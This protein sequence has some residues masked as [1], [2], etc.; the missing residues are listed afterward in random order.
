[1]G[2]D[3]LRSFIVLLT[4]CLSLENQLTLTSLSENGADSAYLVRQLWMWYEVTRKIVNTQCENYYH[5]KHEFPLHIEYVHGH[6][7]VSLLI[8]RHPVWFC[9]EI[10]N[11]SSIPGIIQNSL[12]TCYL[13]VSPSNA[14]SRTRKKPKSLWAAEM[15]NTHRTLAF[16]SRESPWLTFDG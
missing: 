14:L 11:G 10:V 13:A 6:K 12:V 5:L 3:C 15:Q 2:S 16:S 1:M 7:Y 8:G 9:V 4:L